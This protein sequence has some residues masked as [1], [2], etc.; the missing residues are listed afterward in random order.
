MGEIY[1][2]LI[3]EILEDCPVSSANE[4]FFLFV[5]V[6]SATDIPQNSHLEELAHLASGCTVLSCIWKWLLVVLSVDDGYTR[7]DTSLKNR[8]QPLR[9]PDHPK[10]LLNNLIMHFNDKI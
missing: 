9:Y 7:E 3:P 8:W 5:F 6:F 1:A 4:F 10:M 2:Q